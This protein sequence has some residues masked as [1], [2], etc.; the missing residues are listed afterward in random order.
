[1][2]CF[3]KLPAQAKDKIALPEPRLY[4]PFILI[5]YCAVIKWLFQFQIDANAIALSGILAMIG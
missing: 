5:T 2:Q 4:I 3:F 1:M